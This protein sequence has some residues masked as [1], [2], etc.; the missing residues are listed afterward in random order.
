MD[1]RPYPLP[2]AS[3]REINGNTPMA[4]SEFL[5]SLDYPKSPNFLEKGK[6]AFATAPGVGH[7]FRSATK[8]EC[9]LLGVYTLNDVENPVTTTYPIVYVCQAKTEQAAD[10]VHRLVWNQDIVPFL[11]VYTPVGI[12]VYSGFEY[13][14]NGD[15]QLFPLRA[16]NEASSIAK[17]FHSQEI[18]SGRLW[19][20]WSSHLKPERRVNWRLL[21]NLRKLDT[22]LQHDFELTATTSHALI[23]KYVYLSYLR[24]RDILSDRKLAAWGI[25]HSDIFGKT[26]SVAKLAQVV[27]NLEDWLNGNIFPLALSG[28]NAPK[29]E[30]V[31]LVAGVFHGDDVSLSGARQ[32]SLDF[33]AYDFSYIPIET[34]SVV[35]EQ[36]LHTPDQDGNSKG[37]EE[38]AYYTPIPV[39]N[40][41]LGEMEQVK[42]LENGVKV[43]DPACGSGAFLVQCYRRLIEKT[44][45]QHRHKKVLPIPLRELL[46][47][48]IF[49]IDRDPDACAVTELSLLLTLLDYV[50]PPDLEDDKRIKLP[51]LRETNI[52]NVDFFDSF[53]TQV[54]KQCF[55]WIVGNPPWKKLNPRK[56]NDNDKLAWQWMQDNQEERPVGGNELARAFAWRV[57]EINSEET[58]IGLF[59]PAMTLFDNRATE[60]RQ[61]FF[62]NV[63][64]RSV[65]NFSNLAEVISAR[66]FRVPS[67]SFFFR[68]PEHESNHEFNS[69]VKVFSPLVANQEVTRPTDSGERV[70]SWCIV[71]NEAEICDIDYADILDG[72]GLPWKI[73]SWGSHNDVRLLRRLSRKFSPLDTANRS[74]M[75]TISQGP[76]LR[77]IATDK[78]EDKTEYFKELEGAKELQTSALARF[79]NVFSFSDKMKEQCKHH[80]VRR[81][82]RKTLEVCRGPH[83]IVSAARTFAV[84]E[85]NY[86]VVPSRQI[87]SVSP[88]DDRD[89]LKALS[90]FLSSDF[91]FYHQFFTATQF[92]VKRD[93]ATL[94]ALKQMPCPL[95]DLSRDGLKPWIS[96][97]LKLGKTTPRIVGQAASARTLFDE[98]DH[99]DVLLA[100]LNDLVSKSL[101]LTE[102]ERT[103]ISDFV[104]VRLELN[105]GKIGRPAVRKPEPAEL[106]LYAKRLQQELDTFV[107][108]ESEHRHSVS[109]VYDDDSGLICIDFLKSKKALPISVSTVD[110]D[111]STVFAKTRKELQ[112]QAGQWLYFNR[113]LRIYEG[114]KTYLFKPMQRFHWTQSQAMVDAS[115]II[116]ETMAAE[117]AVD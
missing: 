28:K 117:G 107:G 116:A 10:E 23:G 89:L 80:H 106:K 52:F 113:N 103:L 39:V 6:R 51:T 110:R 59:L 101:D 20:A 77:L 63:S 98:D 93:R 72:S 57:T 38:G 109:I 1:L 76:D 16:F 18:D 29:S 90:L 27:H 48:N 31:K 96:L 91:A 37:K 71:V 54:Q 65:A 4:L 87:G 88:N 92:G 115:E 111:A 35:Y 34:L 102:R 79:R 30:H 84:Y 100:E 62:S 99:L 19:K 73:A 95:F 11:I 33:Q 2:E 24:H 81:A 5:D 53:P 66:R 83:V 78:G 68:K 114:T 50:D 14:K 36:F 47:D 58:E 44:Y 61:K 43:L 40:Y 86:L 17:Q 21:E 112:H 49:G 85:E 97:H 82:G 94:D 64:L 60:F 46:V 8:S 75:I 56:L 74:G 45:P 15:G 32:L 69:V 3:S 41:M 108:E 12:K 26:A 55:D 13:S 7:I 104:H 42:P 9:G 22:I 70:E 105:D 25:Q 67:A